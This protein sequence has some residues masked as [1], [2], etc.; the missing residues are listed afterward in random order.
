MHALPIVLCLA[1][2]SLKAAADPL[3]AAD[4]ETLLDS[5]KKL[6][7]TV[8]ERTDARFRAAVSAYRS[9]MLSEG[10]AIEFYLK[11]VEKAI[12]EDQHKKAAEFREWKKREDARLS[13]SSM[14]R[15]L[16]HQL[17]W[18]VLSLQA[19]S[20]NADFD[21]LAPEGQRII[22]DLFN[23]TATLNSQQEL[24]GQK[25]TG[26]V[27][28]KAYKVAGVNAA[29]WP[30][31]PLDISEFYEQIQLPQYRAAGNLEALRAC[32]MKRIHQ[33]G[34]L[35]TPL[36]ARNKGNGRSLA[37]D[38]PPPPK[39]ETFLT[40]VQPEL[41]WQMEM[42]LF[43]C[44]DQRAAA[45]RMIAHIE[46]HLAHRRAREWSDEFKAQLTPPPTASP[47]TPK[48]SP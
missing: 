29:D 40:D 36:S 46:N 34:L 33:Q 12:F 25:V 7:G 13:E 18:L 38:A 21:K 28:A 11:C 39:L 30:L 17:R 47:T 32:W 26:T 2:F 22:D 6:R 5:L 23:D 44:G 42:D 15:A 4:R 16:M 35:Y 8:T 41:Q 14:H 45:V 9:A 10:A 48:P 1:V 20:E 27:F 43:R 3:T 31:A 24:L 19:A 37:P